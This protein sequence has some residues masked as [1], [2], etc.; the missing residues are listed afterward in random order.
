ML[1]NVKKAAGN[2]P[3]IAK[4]AKA[5]MSP[6]ASPVLKEQFNRA[7]KHAE[8]VKQEKK[9]IEKMEREAV[10]A[11]QQASEEEKSLTATLIKSHVE[12]EAERLKA[13]KL[14]DNAAKA[15]AA[16]KVVS[17]IIENI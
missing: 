5:A 7:V 17:N 11:Q 14:R 12:N 13:E 6:T 1:N 2:S 8:K 4:L 3:A 9:A 15:E 16:A 10:K